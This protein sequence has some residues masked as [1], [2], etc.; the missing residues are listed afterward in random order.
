MAVATTPT[1]IPSRRVRTG[2][3]DLALRHA[4]TC[5]DHLAGEVAVAMADRMVERGDVELSADG[6]VL[7]DKGADLLRAIGIDLD[8][9]AARSKGKRVLCRPCLDWSERRPHIAGTIGTAM[10]ST[11][12]T[13]GWVR[14]VEQSRAITV[15]PAGR[16]A[17]ERAFSFGSDF[18]DGGHREAVRSSDCQT[19]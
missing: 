8:E 15:T 16:L 10:L 7:T 9:A 1:G 18:W 3:K 5:Y 13:R 6:G 12:L 11:Y 14:R 4:R 2:P 17:F 19:A